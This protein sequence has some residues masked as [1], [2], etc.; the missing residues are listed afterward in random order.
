MELFPGSAG[1]ATRLAPWVLHTQGQAIYTLHAAPTQ[2]AF[3]GFWLALEAVLS[4]ELRVDRGNAKHG[5]R[6]LQAEI[7]DPRSGEGLTP[8]AWGDRDL[9]MGP[10]PHSLHPGS[11]IQF[12][13]PLELKLDDPSGPPSMAD[14]LRLGRNRLA[15][16]ARQVGRP[17]WPTED[18]RWRQLSEAATEARWSWIQ[19]EQGTSWGPVPKH[20]FQL[21]GG[22]RGEVQ[23]EEIPPAWR[24]WAGLLPLVGVGSHIP[25]G[26][27]VGEAVTP[28]PRK[29]APAPLAQDNVKKMLLQW[30][31][32]IA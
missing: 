2:E 13:T 24:G 23:I 7:V 18:E 25:F 27:G 5:P 4:Q 3:A 30:R 16:L 32:G 12:S 29:F 21:S 28:E 26:C 6:W 1:N 8:L 10:A 20:H 22:W 9:P 17:I 19:A 11:A 31:S 15:R 14:W